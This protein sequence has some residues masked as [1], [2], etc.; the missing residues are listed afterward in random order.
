MEWPLETKIERERERERRRESSTAG[1]T[2]VLGTLDIPLL[3]VPFEE[4]EA[5]N[6]W[7]DSAYR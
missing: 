4:K 5:L 3:N 2:T 6:T 7:H 1:K